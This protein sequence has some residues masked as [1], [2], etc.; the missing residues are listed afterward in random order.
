M[1]QS[2]NIFGKTVEVKIEIPEI[3][4]EL[5]RELSIYPTSHQESNTE[6]HIVKKL[7]D[8]DNVNSNPKIHRTFPNGFGYQFDKIKVVFV[9][10]KKMK[11]YVQPILGS[12]LRTK[13]NKIKRIDFESPLERFG[14][15]FHELVL[16]PMV[17]LLKEYALIHA[18]AFKSPSGKVSLIGGTGGVGKTSLEVFFCQRKGFSFLADDISVI[19]SKGSIFPN[20]S[21]P[22]IYG[23]NLVK[24]QPLKKAIFENRGVFDR[25][26]WSIMKNLLGPS[27]VRRRIDPSKVY[28]IENQAQ[29]I[30]NY[31]ILSRTSSDEIK[32]RAISS[33]IASRM[34]IDII[35][36]EYSQILRHIH[37]HN[38]NCT[39]GNYT[40][41]I[42][43]D[44][45]TS[46]M[47]I[48]ITSSLSSV[49]SGIK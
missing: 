2:Y 24:N 35:L 45:L 39:I 29:K 33:E 42:T 11:I 30:D 47:K 37:W 3:A 13:L 32:C 28:K 46:K 25:L 44:A 8:F 22:K 27:Y 36:A 4:N 20:L 17:F 19:D 34:T 26:Q 48:N 21:F 15:I 14:M 9:V 40:P 16:V 1:K 18:S 12:F 5:F 23:Y 43:P 38:Y 41:V 49:N 10:G 31:Y 6:I 7:P